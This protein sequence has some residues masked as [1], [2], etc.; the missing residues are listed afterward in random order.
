MK[1]QFAVVILFS[2]TLSTA[3]V[4]SQAAK[5]ASN[6][7]LFCSTA[8]S[9]PT[10]WNVE[11]IRQRNALESFALS[12]WRAVNNSTHECEISAKRGDGTSRMAENDT[13]AY[14][15]IEST[16][17]VALFALQQNPSAASPEL[18][19][20]TF[21]KSDMPVSCGSFAVPASMVLKLSGPTCTIEIP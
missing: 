19:L 5:S 6:S 9:E 2:I 21:T 18:I 7:R 11:I 10:Q 4:Q 12:G 15:R 14:I 13:A 1:Y 20:S 3:N 16:S 17:S 8:E